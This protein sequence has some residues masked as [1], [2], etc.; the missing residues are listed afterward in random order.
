MNPHRE[1]KK[2][3]SSIHFKPWYS[4]YLWRKGFRYP[5]NRTLGEPQSAFGCFVTEKSSLQWD[6]NLSKV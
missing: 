4:L 2:I 3:F 6:S 1:R 5:L